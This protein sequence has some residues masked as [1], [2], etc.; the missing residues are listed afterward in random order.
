MMGKVNFVVYFLVRDKVNNLNCTGSMTKVWKVFLARRKATSEPKNFPVWGSRLL[1]FMS[2]LRP[3]NVMLPSYTLDQLT[4]NFS[5]F[6]KGKIG[7][8]IFLSLRVPKPSV[9]LMRVSQARTGLSYN[10]FS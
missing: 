8:N 6:F 5:F 7:I 1:W 2:V 9:M 4:Y 10:S 3:F